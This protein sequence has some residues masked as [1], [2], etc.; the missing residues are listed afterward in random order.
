[1]SHPKRLLVTRTYAGRFDIAPAQ[2]LQVYTKEISQSPPCFPLSV[3]NP[4]LSTP[5]MH[6]VHPCVIQ[7]CPIR[8][9]FLLESPSS[10]KSWGLFTTGIPTLLKLYQVA[11]KHRWQKPWSNDFTKKKCSRSREASRPES[12]TG[13]LRNLRGHFCRVS[14]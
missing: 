2:Q 5:C 7:S 1:M 3:S 9:D 6:I 4:P 8:L 10:T 11:D 13:H 14:D 12:T